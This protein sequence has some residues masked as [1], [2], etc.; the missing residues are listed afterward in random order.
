MDPNNQNSQLTQVL[1]HV[2]GLI[3]DDSLLSQNDEL[4]QDSD[5]GYGDYHEV[6][7]HS[8][9]KHKGSILL[10]CAFLTSEDIKRYKFVFST[11]VATMGNVLPTAILTDQCKSIKATI[12]EVLSDTIHRYCIWHIMTKLPAKLKAEYLKR[13][14]HCEIEKHVDFDVVE[15]VEKYSVTIFSICSDFHGNQFVY[16]VDYRPNNQYL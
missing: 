4:D 3:E 14:Y 9:V 10:G 5:G 6:Y 1:N 2:L 7:L 16:T 15:G 13:L 11:W 8:N 12:R